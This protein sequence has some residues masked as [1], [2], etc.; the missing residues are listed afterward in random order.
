MQHDST[1]P[2]SLQTQDSGAGLFYFY[3]YF[4]SLSYTP[5][6]QALLAGWIHMPAP[7]MTP[8]LLQTRDGGAGFSFY[9]FI[10]LA[11]PHCCKHCLRGGSIH[12]A[13]RRP[14]PR[15]K[16]EMVGLVFLFYFFHSLSYTS[17]P[18]ALLAGWIHTPGPTTTPPLLQ[19]RDG[20]AGFF[21]L[22]FSFS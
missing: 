4:Y 15:Y 6:P 5:P 10:L 14:H 19:T 9:F 8:P 12:Q 22:F 13:R 20:G 1:T 17:P 16:R 11:I 21:V 3:F 7:T 18:Q 2:P